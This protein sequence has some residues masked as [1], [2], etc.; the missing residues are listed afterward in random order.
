MEGKPDFSPQPSPLDLPW[1]SLASK[2]PRGQKLTSVRRE[3][4]LLSVQ[5]G[6]WGE[7][8]W[9]AAFLGASGASGVLSLAKPSTLPRGIV[10]LVP[11]RGT[12][13][14]WLQTQVTLKEQIWT[15]ESSPLRLVSALSPTPVL[16]SFLFPAAFSAPSHFSFSRILPYPS[17][18][19]SPVFLSPPLF[20]SPF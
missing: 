15:S 20:A 13:N 1:S 4:L 14:T 7:E 16:F 2:P 5:G 11:P 6:Q 8:G 10:E 3:A 19:D 18:S 17:L 9:R 12:G